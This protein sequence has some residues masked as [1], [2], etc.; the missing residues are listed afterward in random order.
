MELNFG[1]LG[2]KPDYPPPISLSPLP[3]PPFW[4]GE[5]LEGSQGEE[6]FSVGSPPK[7]N[8]LKMDREE[9]RPGKR[10]GQLKLAAKI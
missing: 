3:C 1:L 7:L 10:V 4:I 5:F 8:R 6:Q 2:L 9:P